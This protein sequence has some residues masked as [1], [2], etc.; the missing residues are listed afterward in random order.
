M[1]GVKKSDGISLSQFTKYCRFSKPTVTKSLKSL[2]AKKLITI[3]KQKDFTGRN[4]FNVYQITGENIGVQEIDSI[5][6]E[7]EKGSK[8]D[9][10]GVAKE[11]CDGR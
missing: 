5:V 2:E 8:G 4:C 6:R 11:I 9:L 7:T 3:T 1:V 10:Q